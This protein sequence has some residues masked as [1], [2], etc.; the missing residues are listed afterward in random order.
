MKRND[1]FPSKWLK[2]ATLSGDA[3]LTI[4]TLLQEELGDDRQEKP[5]LYFKEV[6][7][8][9][10]LNATNYDTIA[11]LYGEET[12][13]WVG[14]KITIYP[15]EVTF[16]GRRLWGSACGYGHLVLSGL[17]YSPHLLPHPSLNSPL[18]LISAKKRA[19]NNAARRYNCGEP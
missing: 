7:Q 12:D 11:S 5:V 17:Q 15:T 14:K 2:G 10:V 8:G 6:E 1:L 9:L 4:T 3:N 18:T 16:S 19:S 13:N